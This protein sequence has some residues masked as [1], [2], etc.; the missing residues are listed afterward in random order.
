ML[1]AL[2]LTQS[3]I[4]LYAVHPIVVDLGLL[5]YFNGVTIVCL[6]VLVLFEFVANTSK[7]IIEL[8]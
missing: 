6:C 7:V 1:P 8:N 5:Q 3:Q 4:T 2:Y